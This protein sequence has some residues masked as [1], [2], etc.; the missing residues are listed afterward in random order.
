MTMSTATTN[1]NQC[2]NLATSSPLRSGG[3]RVDHVLR[4]VHLAAMHRTSIA[5]ALLALAGCASL[6]DAGPTV[7]QIEDQATA[8]EGALFDMVTIDPRVVDVLRAEA[9]PVGPLYM[10][11]SIAPSLTIRVGDTVYEIRNG[12]GVGVGAP[13]YG[14]RRTVLAGLM[15]HF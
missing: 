14:L 9:R 13:Q 11:H 3:A 6:P 5:L 4:N 2:V 15:Q 10:L 8:P 1:Q 7:A 12:T